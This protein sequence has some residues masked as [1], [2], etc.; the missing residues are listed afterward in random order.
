VVAVG[1]YFPID[2]DEFTPRPYGLTSVATPVTPTSPH[3]QAGV[4]WTPL[5]VSGSTTYMTCITG[6]TTVA[7]PAKSATYDRVFQGARPFTV[8]TEFDCSP[9]GTWDDAEQ[10]ALTSLTRA[11]Q[12]QIEQT[13]WTG[14][15]GGQQLIYPNLNT[16]G[17]I[18]DGAEI[19]LQPG[20]TFISGA[21]LD[22]VEGLGR[23]ENAL[24]SCW[25][26]T[27]II[28]VPTIL[29]PA[30]CSQGL[31]Y[32]VGNELYTKNGNEVV[33]GAGYQFNRGPGGATA[34]AGSGWIMA[35][36]PAFYITGPPRVIDRRSSFDRGVNTLKM[37]SERTC[38]V[39]Y[40]CCLAGVLV[41]TGG[42]PVGTPNA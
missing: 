5:C 23:L 42:E 4:T 8:V 2:F 7:P 38:V 26:G 16:I 41:S 28:H 40:S 17:P 13:F 30:M 21:P 6:G 31:I 19:L 24:A 33:A 11:E 32:V 20:G 25:D 18:F 3:W 29:I 34:P 15:A 22:I 37:I 10:I 1:T 9:A 35:T 36:G 12:H 39:G 14:I 27:G